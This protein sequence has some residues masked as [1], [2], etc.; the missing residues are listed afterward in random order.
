MLSK[1]IAL[2]SLP[3]KTRKIIQKNFE[4]QLKNNEK[5]KTKNSN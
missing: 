3:K 1:K 2:Q 5:P 4:K